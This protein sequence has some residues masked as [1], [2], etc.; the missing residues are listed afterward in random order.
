MT[1]K[2]MKKRSAIPKYMHVYGPK[3]DILGQAVK[4]YGVF[5]SILGN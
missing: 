4:V 1:R 3:H 5:L 2:E